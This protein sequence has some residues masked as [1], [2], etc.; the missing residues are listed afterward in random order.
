MVGLS[1]AAATPEEDMNVLV[2]DGEDGGLWRAFET[3]KACLGLRAIK[4]FDRSDP[5]LFRWALAVAG[6]GH[7]SDEV[8]LIE[9][10]TKHHIFF[11]TN[12]P[13]GVGR[14]CKVIKEAIR[15]Q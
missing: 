5:A 12:I 15:E 13:K 4:L 6:N 11:G 9:R 10:P 3:N 1:H 14:A 8:A 7:G 2:M